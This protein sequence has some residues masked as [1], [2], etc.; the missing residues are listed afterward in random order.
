MNKEE[1][2]HQDQLGKWIKESAHD[3]PSVN[4][5]ETIIN[6]IASQQQQTIYQPVI[7]PI[8]L[9]MIST[10]LLSICMYVLFFLPSDQSEELW[11]LKNIQFPKI[12]FAELL[13]F[14][15]NPSSNLILNSSLL[16]FSILAFIS[17]LFWSRRINKA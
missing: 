3:H 7:S 6:A 15:P 10:C 17:M 9:G 1:L 2:N 12:H 11:S 13:F 4:F 14:L 5:S 8:G 16:A